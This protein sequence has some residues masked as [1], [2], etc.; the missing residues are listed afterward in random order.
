MNYAA[1]LCGLCPALNQDLVVSETV[2]D[3]CREL[4]TFREMPK[5]KVKGIAGEPTLWAVTGPRR[6]G[7]S[8]TS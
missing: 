7:G 2:Y 3:A 4:H 5:I 8:S 6:P 1:R